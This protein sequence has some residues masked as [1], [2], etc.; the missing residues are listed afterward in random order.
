MATAFAWRMKEYIAV[1]YSNCPRK[2]PHFTQSLPTACAL[3]YADQSGQ[4]H[5]ENCSDSTFQRWRTT[6]RL[7]CS[8]MLAKHGQNYGRLPQAKCRDRD[9]VSSQQYACRDRVQE[10]PH[11]TAAARLQSVTP[12]PTKRSRPA[13]LYSSRFPCCTRRASRHT[14]GA[15]W[16]SSTC[17]RQPSCQR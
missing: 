14:V 15:S 3:L 16:T 5:S 6:K 1:R 4:H 7:S 9:C 11:A 8:C 13:G 2:M 10:A 17:T 12:R